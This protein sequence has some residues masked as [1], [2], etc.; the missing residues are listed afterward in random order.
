MATDALALAGL[1][2]MCDF[3]WVD[4]SPSLLVHVLCKDDVPCPH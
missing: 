2:E 1:T 4:R 3:V